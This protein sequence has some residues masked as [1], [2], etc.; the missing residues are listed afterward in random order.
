MS[1]MSSQPTG[2]PRRI[3]PLYA[4]LAVAIAL[5]ALSA[6]CSRSWGQTGTASGREFTDADIGK[7]EQ[8][9][10]TEFAR[11][12]GLS[13]V[14]VKM[15]MESPTRLTG[16]AKIRTESLGTVEKACEA[17]MSDRGLPIWQCN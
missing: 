8:S 5:S 10:K 4:A 14:A 3:G 6:G 11:R 15:V 17:S 13:V 1:D 16:T 7:V 12:S 9:I 2:S